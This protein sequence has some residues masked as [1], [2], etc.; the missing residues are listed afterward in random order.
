MANGRRKAAVPCGKSFPFLLWFEALQSSAGGIRS[1]EKLRV[2]A[3][4]LLNPCRELQILIQNT[5]K[6]CSPG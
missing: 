1:R 2:K 4:L 6:R 3:E 5:A